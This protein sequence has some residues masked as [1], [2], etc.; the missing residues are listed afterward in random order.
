MQRCS[1]MFPQGA[2]SRDLQLET[3]TFKYVNSREKKRKKPKATLDSLDKVSYQSKQPKAQEAK[4]NPALGPQHSHSGRGKASARPWG[5]CGSTH[6]P[7]CSTAFVS[8]LPFHT[9][10]GCATLC[11]T[12]PDQGQSSLVNAPSQWREPFRAGS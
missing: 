8:H 4:G 1:S 7:E 9:S 5:P 11:S 12:Q 3:S 2:V 10:S 6:F